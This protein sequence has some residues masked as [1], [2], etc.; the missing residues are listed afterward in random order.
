MPLPVPDG[1]RGVLAIS[2]SA[3]SAFRRSV[4]R[5]RGGQIVGDLS[6][7]TR[8]FVETS[9]SPCNN[10]ACACCR[11][12]RETIRVRGSTACFYG[13]LCYEY[14]ASPSSPNDSFNVYR[15]RAGQADRKRCASPA[16]VLE[17][18]LGFGDLA[19]PLRGGSKTQS[20][21]TMHP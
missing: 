10:V 5:M 19:V 8:I 1:S 11:S 4:P 6:D 18:A 21:R 9:H 3:G 20:G 17:R 13:R 16:S 15:A 12:E 2:P 7:L 14:W